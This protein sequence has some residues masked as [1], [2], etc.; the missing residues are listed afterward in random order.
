[1]DATGSM[2]SLLSQAKNMVGTMFSRVQAILKEHGLEE[3]AFQLQFAVYRDYDQ[4]IEGILVAS[5]WETKADVLHSFMEKVPAAGGDD[6]PEAIEVGLWHANYERERDGLN[7]VILIGDAPAKDVS[8]ITEYRQK[9]G[10]ESYWKSNPKFSEQTHYTTEVAKLKDYG[11]PVHCFWMNTGCTSNFQEIATATGGKC[12][13]LEVNLLTDVV[14]SMVL[15]NVGQLNGKGDILM[16]TY[17]ARFG[18]GHK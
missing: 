1:M 16:E 13:K 17:R 4:K 14:S 5:G 12:N 3:T 15:Q 6:Y 10:G 9:Y 8:A 18:K 11:V 2:D 7:Q